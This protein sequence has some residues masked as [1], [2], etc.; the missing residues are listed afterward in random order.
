MRVSIILILHDM[1]SE[2]CTLP[3]F[4][5][6]A[7]TVHLSFLLST[8]V[9]RWR[10]CNLFPSPLSCFTLSPV[11]FLARAYRSVTYAIVTKIA[12]LR[13][14]LSLPS[15]LLKFLFMNLTKLCIGFYT[16]FQ[17]ISMYL[18]ETVLVSR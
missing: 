9:L 10:H 8:L 17:K 3:D 4:L 12:S 1:V 14:M 6:S 16:K 15:A 7:V 5:P 2:S 11:D 18:S 13:F